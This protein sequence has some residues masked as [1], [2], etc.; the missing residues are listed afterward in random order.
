[1][2]GDSEEDKKQIQLVNR[3][4]FL[5]CAINTSYIPVLALVGNYSYSWIML[6][7]SLLLPLCW[8]FSM[9]R[10]FRMTS[11]MMFLLLIANISLSAIMNGN[12]GAE[13]LYLPASLVTFIV[14]KRMKESLIVFACMVICFALTL[15]LKNYIEPV[16]IITEL[17]RQILLH[18]DLI[19]IF[20]ASGLAMFNFK[21]VLGKYEKAALIQ[22]LQ[23]EARNKEITDSINYAQRIQFAL[24]ANRELMKKHLP[25]HFILFLP[26]DIVSGD[27]YWATSPHPQPLSLRRGVDAMGG[28]G[29]GDK[30]ANPSNQ[31]FFL[32]VCDSTGHG[33][34]G[35]FMS[36][37]NISFL[38]EAVN[39]RKLTLPNEILNYV[40]GRLIESLRSELDEEGGKDG[41][42][43]VLLCFEK[44]SNTL[45]F[46][47]AQNPLILIRGTEVI[48]YTPDRMP[49]GKSPNDQ[50]PF[51]LQTIDLQKGDCIYALTD[52]YAD[53]FGGPKGKKFRQKS[54]LDKLMAG[55]KMSMEDQ[56]NILAR[57]LEEWKQDL[58]QVDDVCVI[59]IRV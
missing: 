3:I 37:L 42:D 27:F 50:Q 39:E 58:E 26:K 13:F 25:E 28:R 29:E 31:L 18:T 5:V 1:M 43:C 56:K 15:I 22:K 44:G 40:R 9:R 7:F 10:M 41:M 35:A 57:E 47:C 12:I 6:G 23:I 53:Q 49:V 16:N 17:N 52:G 51:T 20:I 2:P 24:L 32:A 19:M 4:L 30:E 48:R 38:N 34:P 21:S 54:L 8:I 36:L 11:V 46:S 45:K 55:S 59:G 14:F 33:V